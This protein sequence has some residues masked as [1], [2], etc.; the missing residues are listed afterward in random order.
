MKR[1]ESFVMRIIPLG[2][3]IDEQRRAYLET[4]DL[5]RPE[6]LGLTSIIINVL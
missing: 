6:T 1:M 2:R 4:S 3:D 5:S